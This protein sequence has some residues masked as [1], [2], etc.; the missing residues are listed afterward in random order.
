MNIS[1]LV[2]ATHSTLTPDAPPLNTGLNRDSIA[3][4]TLNSSK[5][6][7]FTKYN[8]LEYISVHD[9]ATPTPPL[10]NIE[11][12]KIMLGA[13]WPPPAKVRA[14]WVPMPVRH[15]KRGGRCLGGQIECSSAPLPAGCH[16]SATDGSPMARRPERQGSR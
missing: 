16:R 7:V 9:R 4:S 2:F 11:I 5:C 14:A 3:V 15:G 10:R 6:I 8:Q 1:I 13:G 12:I